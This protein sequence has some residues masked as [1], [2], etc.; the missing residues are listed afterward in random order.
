[1]LNDRMNEILSEIRELE[2][3]VQEELKRREEE[4]RYSVKGE[5][6]FEHEHTMLHKNSQ[7]LCSSMCSGPPYSYV[8]SAPSY[9]CSIR[10]TLPHIQQELQ[11]GASSIAVPLT[12]PG[13]AQR[14]SRYHQFFNY[15]D[16]EAYSNTNSGN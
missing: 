10:S 3:S 13:K 16:A 7:G 11:P 14:P 5:V 12:M 6:P 4:L 9:I 2:E 15:G 8:L 1:M